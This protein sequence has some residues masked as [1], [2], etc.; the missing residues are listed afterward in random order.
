MA[1]ARVRL[2]QGGLQEGIANLRLVA[3]RDLGPVLWNECTG[4]GGGKLPELCGLIGYEQL[5]KQA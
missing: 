3:I 4:L 5:E 1:H 2:M